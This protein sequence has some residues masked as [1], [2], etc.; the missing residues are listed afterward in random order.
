MDTSNCSFMR[1]NESNSTEDKNRIQT[2]EEELATA[3]EAGLALLK[4]NQELQER[5]EKE[6]LFYQKQIEVI[7]YPLPTIPYYDWVLLYQ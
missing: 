2:L 7:H 4:S 5:C 1:K 6:A 3:A